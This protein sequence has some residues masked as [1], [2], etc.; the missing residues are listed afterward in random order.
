M[1]IILN[2]YSIARRAA[3]VFVGT[4]MLEPAWKPVWGLAYWLASFIV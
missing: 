3:E 4:Y 1:H 2:I